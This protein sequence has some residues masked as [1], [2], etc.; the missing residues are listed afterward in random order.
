[1]LG[2]DDQW[3]KLKSN[4]LSEVIDMLRKLTYLAVLA[5]VS[6]FIQSA[7][8]QPVQRFTYPNSFLPDQV[9]VIQ[10]NDFEAPLKAVRD[11]DGN[12]TSYRVF[13]PGES[14][15]VGDLLVG[16]Y[17]MESLQRLNASKIAQ[18]DP[19][20]NPPENIT[21]AFIAEVSSK[22]QVGGIGP[23]TFKFDAAP[24]LAWTALGLTRAS[25]QTIIKTFLDTTLEQSWIANAAL[26][27][28][29]TPATI[30][31]KIA[32]SL[33][34]ANG[35]MLWEFGMPGASDNVVDSDGEFWQSVVSS[36]VPSSISDQ[37][38]FTAGMN[39]TAYGAG[40]ELAKLNELQNSEFF[41]TYNQDPGFKGWDLQLI[42]NFKYNLPDQAMPVS[43]NA[44]LLIRPVPEPG[45]LVV[46]M[47]IS[48]TACVGLRRARRGKQ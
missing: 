27:L 28:G 25:S 11:N 24:D 17:E 12:V 1:M 4:E 26:A 23:F 34:T 7:D 45:S 19:F 38:E 29:D 33:A 35:S 20:S 39:L 40:F 48:G 32:G 37:T 18:P 6:V 42:G 9:N 43:S 36:D 21:G 16:I 47:L 22:T 2:C 3:I 13:A 44:N 5:G 8:A 41:K 15:N 10:D 31:A 46:W 30:L 14:L